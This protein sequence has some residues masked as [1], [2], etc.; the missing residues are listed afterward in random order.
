MNM[1]TITRQTHLDEIAGL[2]ARGYVRLRQK[3]AERHTSGDHS[4][5]GRDISLDSIRQAERFIGTERI[6]PTEDANGY[7][8]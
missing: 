2:L 1:K 8:A 5:D 3:R 4:P 7:F 6:S